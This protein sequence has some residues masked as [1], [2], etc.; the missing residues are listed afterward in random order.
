MVY[1][2]AAGWGQDPVKGFCGHGEECSGS[3]TTGFLDQV[4]N[5]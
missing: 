3:I 2:D 1:E 4:N 5:D